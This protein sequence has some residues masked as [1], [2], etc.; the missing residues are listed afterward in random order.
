[1]RV[2]IFWITSP[3]PGDKNENRSRKKQHQR[4]KNMGDWDWRKIAENKKPDP[5]HGRLC[6]GY[7]RSTSI[8]KIRRYS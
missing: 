7:G 4:P 3:K 8:P 6:D 5:Q 1:M 2:V